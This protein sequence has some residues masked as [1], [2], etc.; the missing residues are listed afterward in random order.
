[1]V[2]G[3]VEFHT[4]VQPFVAHPERALLVAVAWV[5]LALIMRRRP[6]RPLLIA[7]AAW[8]I[9]A[10]LEAQAKR[11]HADVRMDLPVTWTALCMC[12]FVCAGWW[13]GLSSPRHHP[14]KP[15]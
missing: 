12:T 15:L 11:A 9:F 13:L 3:R 5:A 4:W 6:P 14:P 7:A 2:G 1:M 8:A 10:I